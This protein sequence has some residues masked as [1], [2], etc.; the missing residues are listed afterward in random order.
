MRDFD[1]LNACEARISRLERKLKARKGKREYRHSVPRIEAEIEHL[2]GMRDMV[3]E[4]RM[5]STPDGAER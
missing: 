5:A 2:K 3:R 1:P 4:A